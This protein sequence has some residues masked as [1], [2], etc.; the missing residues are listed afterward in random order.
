MLV[1]ALCGVQLAQLRQRIHEGGRR[2]HVVAVSMGDAGG[3]AHRKAPRSDGGVGGSNGDAIV[4]LCG[5]ACLLATS[6]RTIFSVAL[7]PL[8]EE[9]GI[10]ATA[11]G[12]LQSSFLVGCVRCHFDPCPLHADVP[13][14]LEHAR[15]PCLF[16]TT[17]VHT[18]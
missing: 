6:Q 16:R 14:V 2:A 4:L 3:A 1:P 7:V 9:L 13:T 5:A 8:R 18:R 15:S 11:A 17:H 12:A 10:S